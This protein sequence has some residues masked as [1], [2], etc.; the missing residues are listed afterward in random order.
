[1]ITSILI[2][3]IVLSILIFFHELGHF[4]AAKA[5]NI[6]VDRFS[7]GMPPR[8]FG[9]KIGETD[10]CLGALPIGGFVKMAGQEDAP[11]TEDEREAQYGGVPEERWFN[12]RPVWQRYIVVLAGPFMN[13]VLAIALYSTMAAVGGEV[14]ES[15]ISPRIGMVEEGSPAA[16]APL[17]LERPGVAWDEYDGPPDAVGWQTGDL[18]LEM[19]GRPL[20][21][22]MDLAYAA[23]LR[24]GR[25][26][27]HVLLERTDSDGTAKRYVS[28]ITPRILGDEKNPRFGVA[29][30][31]TAIVAESTEGL[32]AA[33]AGLF[34]GDEILR[35]NGNPVDSSTFRALTERAEPGS[36]IHLEVRRNGEF[37]YFDI[38][39]KTVGRIRGLTYGVSKKLAR[40]EIEQASPE[41]LAVSEELK[42]SAGIQRRDVIV[43][44]NGE[45]ATLRRMRA[46]E[47]ENPD[48]VLTITV[49]RPAVLFGVIQRADILT[50]ELP[51]NAVR[52][53]GVAMRPKMVFHRSPPSQW[54]PEGFRQSYKALAIT[55]STLKALIMRDVSA[56]E[57]GGP[58][59]IAT[60]VAHAAEGGLFWLLKLTAFISINLCV[61]NLLPLPVLDGG[62]LVI[63][64]YE[65]VRR[66]PLNPV[67]LERFQM[68]GLLFIIALMLFVTYNDIGRLIE[69]I[70]P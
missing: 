29:P 16:T 60:V 38:T 33:A 63:H 32:P 70:T 42:E 40:D 69:N 30:F 62:L 43:A 64:G 44:V 65:A 35:A 10:Y 7:I 24:G 12:R 66:K 8:L 2:F 59:M 5:C 26:E 4:V 9:V 49:R 15:E 48:G 46:L 39:P 34:P 51:V 54:I 25:R 22:F 53:V 3:L 56:T 6:Y 57:L 31:E 55:I 36:V 58:V 21:N 1:M 41:V 14:P 50:L 20:A 45:P 11:L 52:A 17:Y 13:F 27:F 68:I 18:P 19:D 37:L 47:M 23:A 67:F 28:R 61:F